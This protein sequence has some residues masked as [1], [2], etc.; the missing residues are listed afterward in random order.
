MSE[1]EDEMQVEKRD[2][3]YENVAFDKILNRVKILG[4][5]NKLSNINYSGLIMKVIDQLY[6]KIPT[7]AIDEL[8]AVQCA[9][10]STTHYD[11]YTLAGLIV[12]SN[13]QKNSNASFYKCV[14]Y[15]YI[16]T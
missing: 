16:H 3:S 10:M 7:T 1:L 5:E 11:Y 14:E 15:L 6:D 2:G 4:K 9:S 13:Y 8:T 12:I